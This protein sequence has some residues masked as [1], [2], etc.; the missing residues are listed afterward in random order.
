[1]VRELADYD[2]TRAAG[3]L[4]WPL[5]EALISYRVLMV[6]AARAA[7]RHDTAVWASIAPHST[8][9]SE[10]PAVPPILRELQ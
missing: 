3:V 5:R 6:N 10:P 1:M 7:W 4:R 2:V 8:K 9:K